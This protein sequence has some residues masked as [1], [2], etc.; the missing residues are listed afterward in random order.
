MTRVSP[1]DGR[2]AYEVAACGAADVDAAVQSA[3]RSF[4]DGRW[5]R[6]APRARK[7]VLLALA[8]KVLDHADELALL[9]TLDM[10][11]PIAESRNADVPSAAGVVAWYAEAIDKLYGEVAPTQAD[12]LAI[13]TPEPLGVVGAIIPWNFPLCTAS[14]KLAPALAAGN[15]VVLKPSEKSPSSALRLAEL[16]IEAGLPPGVLNVVPGTGHDA[17]QALAL[18]DDVDTVTF[19]GSTSTGQGILECA[20][21]SNMKRVSLECGGKS[22]FI[23]FPG[24]DLEAAAKA[25]VAGAF[26]NQGAMCS[27]ASRL[28]VHPSIRGELVERVLAAAE[29]WLVGDPLNETTKVGAI[30]DAGHMERVLGHVRV[31]LEEGA[32]LRVG[33][34][35]V[36]RSS[37]GCFIAPAVFD[38][39]HDRMRIAQEEIFGPVLSILSFD[40]VDDAIRIANGVSYG[41]A[42]AVWTRDVSLAHRVARAL[43]AGTVY[44]NCYDADDVTV[45]FGGSAQSGPRRA[46]SVHALAKYAELATTWIPL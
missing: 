17:G 32:A 44:V 12:V 6:L 11:K 26:Y 29:Q 39:V 35:R 22:A 8:R 21:R 16:A 7:E 3:R 4:E 2:T 45:P 43:R 15:S 19:T 24:A 40:D 28:L 38:G 25:A 10:G 5:C 36:S 13:V 46:E 27:A 1:L 18:H 33:G 30:V 9:E 31:G 34:H 14:W 20:G 23:V 37:G 42:A 41:L